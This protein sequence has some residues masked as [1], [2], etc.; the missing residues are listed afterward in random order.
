MLTPE[1]IKNLGGSHK[2]ELR[3]IF[4]T[5]E[6]IG[7]LKNR[8]NDLKNLVD[9]YNARADIFLKEIVT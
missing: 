4:L 6:D 8:I 9:Y 7:G 5:K 2:E 3:Q 1:D